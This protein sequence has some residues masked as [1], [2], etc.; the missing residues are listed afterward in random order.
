MKLGVVEYLVGGANDGEKLAQ[1]RRLGAGGLEVIVTRQELRDTAG[2]RLSGLRRAAAQTGVAIPSLM[3]LHHN[4]GGIGS[5]DPGTAAAAR[6]DVRAAI[7]WAAELGAAVILLPFFGRGE[8]ATAAD[9][10]RATA[11]FREL[12]PRAAARGVKLCLEGTLAAPEVA[13]MAAE[14]GS[15]GFGCYFDLAN[16][17]W[18]GFDP[19]TEIRVLGELVAQVHFKDTWVGPGDRRPGR[20]R[21]NF[22]ECAAAL[23]ETGYDGWLVME[24]PAGPAELVARDI[25][26]VA[27]AFGGLGSRRP[28][29]RWGAF[30]WEYGRGQLDL[31]VERFRAA[32]LTALQLAG[33]LLEEALE[34]AAVLEHMRGRLAEGG[35]AVV[36]L[37]AYR[38]LV[39]ADAELRRRNIEFVK[40]CLRAAPLFET[41]VVATEAGTR[42]PQSDWLPAAEN[43]G[44]EAW[45]LLRAALDELV[46]VAREHGSILALE[47]YVHHVLRH[48]GQLLALL[49]RF[50]G[51]H[52][53]AVLDP[54]NYLSRW[55]MPA[56]ERVVQEFLDRFED[57]FVLA[58]LKDVDPAGAEEG[59]PAFGTGAFPQHIY[60]EFLRRR[61]PDLAVILEH[62]PGEAIVAAI[63][64]AERILR[65]AAG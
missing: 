3:L 45:G 20:G 63:E 16:A 18:R 15:A 8:L 14:V 10:A 44:E 58:H 55:V 30:C 4:E 22:Q 11:A 9:R 54:Y 38:N 23:G 61:R 17:L 21:V 2:P 36:A 32:G 25:S 51:P 31:L 47:G 41:S 13:A 26:F 52:L 5:P 12:C 65:G 46:P 59:T 49:E 64:R 56:R 40:R 62:L 1:A 19:P 7:E 33:P 28:W 6:E 43:D 27:L 24:T 57:R 39:A 42:N 34:S 37:G 50:E 29:P 35:I 60:L 53:Q 48:P